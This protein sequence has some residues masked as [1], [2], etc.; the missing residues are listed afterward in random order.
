MKKVQQGIETDGMM[1]V[2]PE[3]VPLAAVLALGVGAAMFSMGRALLNDPTVRV[4]QT[5]IRPC[6]QKLVIVDMILGPDESNTTLQ[7]TGLTY[8]LVATHTIQEG[9]L[10]RSDR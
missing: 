3:L 5:S 2:P 10:I 8:N 4:A 7:M 1:I 6:T 9:S